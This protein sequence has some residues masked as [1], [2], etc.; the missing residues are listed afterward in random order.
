MKKKAF[1]LVEI[2]IVFALIMIVSALVIP[3]VLNDSKTVQD[4]SVSVYG[5]KQ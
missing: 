3:L 1:T 4:V 2:M 5:Y